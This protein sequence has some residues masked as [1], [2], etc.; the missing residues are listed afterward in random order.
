MLLPIPVLVSCAGST[1]RRTFFASGA[2]YALRPSRYGRLTA[3]CGWDGNETRFHKG[4]I[5]GS[6]LENGYKLY[7]KESVL[8][9]G[10]KL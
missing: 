1:M 2:R 7:V 6:V 4:V 10:Y 3:S 8:E 5:K 9:N